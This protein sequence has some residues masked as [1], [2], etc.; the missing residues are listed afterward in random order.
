MKWFVTLAVSLAGILLTGCLH[1][2]TQSPAVAAKS[3]TIVTLDNSLAGTVVSYNA[4]GRFLVLNFPAHRMPQAG[5]QLFLYRA[6]LKIAEVKVTGPQ[7]EENIVADL[8]SG[9]ARSGD[10]VRDR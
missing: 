9:D 5:Q 7:D 1:S 10:E 2:R 6:G 3:T 8:I 4:V